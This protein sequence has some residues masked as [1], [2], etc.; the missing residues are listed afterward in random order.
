MTSTFSWREYLSLVG[1]RPHSQQPLT[2]ARYIPAVSIFR[3]GELSIPILATT[4]KLIIN[5]FWE[6]GPDNIEWKPWEKIS[7]FL[8][9]FVTLI[10]LSQVFPDSIT[11]IYLNNMKKV[12]VSKKSTHSFISILSV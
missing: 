7:I 11:I 12:I 9:F 2:P 10:S 1:S 3:F 8:L 5:I 4:K 6:G